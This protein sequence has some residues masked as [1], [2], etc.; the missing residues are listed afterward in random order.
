MRP[1]AEAALGEPSCGVSRRHAVEVQEERRDAAVHRLQPVH[2]R[3]LRQPVEEALSQLALVFPDRL[4]SA[5][6]LEVRDRRGE[7]REQLVRRGARLEAT[8]DRLDRRRARLV[9]APRLEQ[10]VTAVGDA[11]VRTAELVRRRDEDVAAERL[12]VGRHVGRVLHGVDPAERA[13]LVRELGDARHVDDRAER[14]R[15][16]DARDDPRPLVQLPREVVVVEQQV[17]GD[18]DP[19]D[20]EAAVGGELDPRRDAAVVVEARHENPVAL[21]PVARCGAR[22]G[23]VE[24]GHVLP[25][26]DVVGGAA[27]E[28]AGVLPRGREDPLDALAR[29]VVRADVGRRVAQR[30]RD[31]LADLVRNLRAA[32]RVEEDEVVLEGREPPPDCRDVE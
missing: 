3:R 23:E 7:P 28:A 24:N 13:D 22:E 6:R 10:L 2:R 18:V 20:L 11:E 25:E 17:I 8:A 29:L 21:L 4:H 19:V 9:R 5:D 12:H 31:R 16:A 30:R 1:H 15:R 32:R 14:V 27:E 26:D